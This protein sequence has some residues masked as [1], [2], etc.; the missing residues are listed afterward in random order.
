MRAQPNAAI[1][2]L[3]EHGM[4]ERTGMMGSSNISGRAVAR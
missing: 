4:K 3:H 2:T 1:T